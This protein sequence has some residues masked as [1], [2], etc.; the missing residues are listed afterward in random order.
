MLYTRESVCDAWMCIC[1]YF[2]DMSLCVCMSVRTV[3]SCMGAGACVCVYGLP[4][5]P[6]AQ[7]EICWKFL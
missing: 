6:I 3:S 5:H 4:P 7:P 1:V 2:D